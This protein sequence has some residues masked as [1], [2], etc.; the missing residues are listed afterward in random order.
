MSSIKFNYVI[1]PEK[2]VNE[3]IKFKISKFGITC[4]P[5]D[6]GSQGRY[7][8]CVSLFT[9]LYNDNAKSEPHK[10]DSKK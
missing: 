5:I 6:L 10:Y 4:R 1:N 2:W 7:K 9:D 8:V 3:K